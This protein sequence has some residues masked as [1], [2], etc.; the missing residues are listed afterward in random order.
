[1]ENT[2]IQIYLFVCQIYDTC[3]ATCF[4]RLSNNSKPDFTDQQLVTIW[5]FAHF[6]D[7]FQKKQLPS[8]IK[9]YWFDW[10]PNLPSYQSFVFRLNE[11]E[12]TFQT[13]GQVL[14]ES[15]EP[16]L[17][18]EID[19]IVDSLPVMLAY[20]RSFLRGESGL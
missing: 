11:L 10:F 6:N 5:L 19:S 14:I 20:A 8:F 3:S 17:A 7:K 15:L 1:M 2:L 13:L 16:K 4:Q 18:T 12:P 9:N